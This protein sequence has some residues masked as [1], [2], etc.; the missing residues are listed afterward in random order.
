M[1][2]ELILFRHAKSS[3]KNSDLRD[4]DRPLNER[5]RRA[6]AKMG[7][8]AAESDLQPDLILSSDSARTRETVA[9]WS[10][11]AGWDGSVRYE[12]ELYHASPDV[13]LGMARRAGPDVE[14]LM[15]V[16]HNPGIEELAS[17]I[18]GRPIDVPTGTMITAAMRGQSWSDATIADFIPAKI[19][20]PR[21]LDD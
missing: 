8:L 18:F 3:W 15:L 19:R 4:H 1:S 6:A 5:G 17:A 16:A 12:P 13:L 9:I 21:E 14:R 7:R 11:A 10:T 2:R 20:R